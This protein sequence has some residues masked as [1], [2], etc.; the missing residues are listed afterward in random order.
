MNM[1]T[2]SFARTAVMAVLCI[3]ALTGC[4][5]ETE[6]SPELSA[7]VTGSYTISTIET[8]GKTYQAGQTNLKGGLTVV[9][10]S[11]TSVGI[12]LNITTKDNG[13]FLQGNVSDVSLTD[14]GNGEVNLVK[15]GDNF[16]K[17]GNGRI[18]VKVS[19][20]NDQDMIITLKK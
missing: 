13:D 12:D 1:K 3:A 16:G 9:R 19:D 17:G 6:P 18:S 20:S 14:A 10:E 8:G 15:S 4:K 7:R 5:K 11:E 2:S